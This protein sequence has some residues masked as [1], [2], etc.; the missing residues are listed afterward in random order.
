MKFGDCN[1][2][3]MKKGSLGYNIELFFRGEFWLHLATMFIFM[4]IFIKLLLLLNISLPLWVYVLLSVLI[5]IGWECFWKY[6]RN[7]FI[8]IYD[9]TAT[10]IGGILSIIILCIL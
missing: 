1:S 9:I 7:G 10:V 6:Y 4:S 8:D 5:G 3:I 2:E